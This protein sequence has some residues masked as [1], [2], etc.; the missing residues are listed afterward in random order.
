MSKNLGSLGL[1]GFSGQSYRTFEIKLFC[2]VVTICELVH[3][4]ESIYGLC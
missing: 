2:F 4:V 3:D 1:A